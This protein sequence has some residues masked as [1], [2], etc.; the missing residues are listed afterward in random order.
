MRAIVGGTEGC[1]G[2]AEFHVGVVPCEGWIGEVDFEAG[3]GGS[4]VGEVADGAGP[5]C[6]GVEGGGLH[7]V[8][9]DAWKTTAA[10]GCGGEPAVAFAGFDFEADGVGF[11]VVDSDDRACKGEG[12]E[13][14]K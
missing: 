4:C 13:G 12:E 14:G 11:G 3:A 6:G 10:G 9:P 7:G 8:D 1:G 5:A 2:D